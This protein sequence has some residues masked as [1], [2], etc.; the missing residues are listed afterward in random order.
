MKLME[1]IWKK[2]QDNKKK[3]VLAEGEEE[4]NIKACEM[5]IKNKLADIV[6]VGNEE[7]V[8]N[9]AKELGVSVDG[10]KIVDPK[11][12]DKTQSYAKTLY[13][14]RKNK[15]MTEEKAAKIILDP[16]YFG[17]MMV[18][19]DDAD[20]MVSGAIH[21]TGDLLRPGLQIVKTAPGVSV[22]SS[23]FIMLVPDSKYGEDGL[24]LFAD[25]AVN[26]NP[27]SD[28]LASI[29]ITTAD[30]AKDLCNMNPK[31]AMLSFS[32]MGSASHELVDKVTTAA[33]VAKGRRPELDIDGELQ[34]DAAIVE[35]VANLKAPN[36]S[37]AGKA[38][39]LV[40]P[41]LQAGNIGYKL[42]QRFANAE[43]IGPI[44]QGFAKPINDLSRG[45]S[46]EDIV[47]VVAVTAVQAQTN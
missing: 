36:S 47:N 13:E 1:E 6:L 14:L 45:C 27:N 23:F 32:T 29:A 46:A 11:T 12:S 22:V 44:T 21:T 42:V 5:I 24:L 3:I 31:V 41:D 19:M 38:N 30:T 17:T 16:L 35:K 9:K 18:K 28:E 15:G 34:L 7:K 8:K 26:P 39:V 33:K 25:C 43:A 40:F 10:A 2:A 4:R 37:V 20:G